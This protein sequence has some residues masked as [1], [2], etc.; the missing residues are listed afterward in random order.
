MN[1]T[2][3]DL[4]YSNIINKCE[5]MLELSSEH[6]FIMEWAREKMLEEEQVLELCNKFPALKKAKDNFDMLKALA[7]NQESK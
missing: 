1:I 5:E 6:A 3:T 7:I 4:Q 2:T